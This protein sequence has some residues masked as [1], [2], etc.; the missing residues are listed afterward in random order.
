MSDS[1]YPSLAEQAAILH[2]FIG[3]ASFSMDAARVTVESLIGLDSH[4]LVPV[5][6]E[7]LKLQRVKLGHMQAA[8]VAAK[9]RGR[10]GMNHHPSSGAPAA[11]GFQYAAQG[12]A[13]AMDCTFERFDDAARAFVASIHSFLANARLPFSATLTRNA[14]AL[15]CTFGELLQPGYAIAVLMLSDESEVAQWI[16]GMPTFLESLRRTVEHA[17]SPGVLVGYACAKYGNVGHKNC[18]EVELWRGGLRIAVGHEL[19]VYSALLERWSFEQLEA[20]VAKGSSI[21]I[22]DDS[23]PVVYALRETEPLI[24]VSNYSSPEPATTSLL[25]RAQQFAKRSLLRSMVKPSA[26]IRYPAGS[27][28]PGSV[29]VNHDA[30]AQLLNERGMS[31]TQLAQHLGI[32]EEELDD[33]FPIGMF[34][35]TASLLGAPDFNQLVGRIPRDAWVNVQSA[36]VL[37]GLI[38]AT[39]QVRVNVSPHFSPEDGAVITEAVEDLAAARWAA[40]QNRAGVIQGLDGAVHSVDAEE[41]LDYLH[42]VECVVRAGVKPFFM[43]IPDNELPAVG[44]RLV[45]AVVPATT[46]TP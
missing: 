9:L 22:G 34:V 21:T 2:S 23:L 30:L 24:H 16:D 3:R 17:G 27:G 28:L 8:Q 43:P 33:D 36:E 6:R 10:R 26:S 39:E 40:E 41:F 32:N 45:I 29:I 15:M 1:A 20:A 19:E 44:K 11:F 46:V 25:K 12:R 13:G 14:R 35:Q 7:Q 4:Q 37:Q 5:L 38:D 42:D 31:K 18:G